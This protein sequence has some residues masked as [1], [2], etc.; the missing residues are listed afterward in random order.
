[1]TGSPV[2]LCVPFVPFCTK[3]RK[4]YSRVCGGQTSVLVTLEVPGPDAPGRR[5]TRMR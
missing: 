5:P 3:G 2:L 4:I 1:M